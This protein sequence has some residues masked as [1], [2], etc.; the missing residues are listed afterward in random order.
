MSIIRPKERR[1]KKERQWSIGGAKAHPP[2]P[3]SR[4]VAGYETPGGLLRVAMKRIIN[5]SLFFASLRGG[6]NW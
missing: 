2:A 4:E 3:F 1:K 6:S 5:P